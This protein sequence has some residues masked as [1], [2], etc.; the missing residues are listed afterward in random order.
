M[1][2]LTQGFF[3]DQDRKTQR[4]SHPAGITSGFVYLAL[5]GGKLSSIDDRNAW[6]ARVLGIQV[7]AADRTVQVN[8]NM[9]SVMKDDGRVRTKGANVVFQ[10]A[11]LLW[12]SA[13]KNAHGQLRTLQ[14][15]ILA[16]FA[17]EPGFVEIKAVTERL[18]KLLE[19]LDERLSDKLDEILNADPLEREQLKGE[20]GKIVADYAAII[21]NHPGVRLL[22]DNPFAPIQIRK[23]FSDV[24]VVLSDKLRA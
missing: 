2:A 10:Q 8:A 22:E 15:S 6:V 7:G 1:D 24:L 4:C 21:E 9:P 16:E 18:D 3:D 20:A 14:K 19:G 23:A 17:G 5:F 13:R 11:R 12:D